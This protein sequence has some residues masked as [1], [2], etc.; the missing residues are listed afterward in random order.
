MAGAF[1]CGQPSPPRDA[2]DGSPRRDYIDKIDKIEATCPTPKVAAPAGDG[3]AP[4]EVID[5]S[6]LIRR[7]ALGRSLARRVRDGALRTERPG[8]AG[9][10]QDLCTIPA[11]GRQ[12]PA[13]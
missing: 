2:L 7:R 5:A 1:V 11:R 4:V 12:L 13:I 6:A 9:K 3:G 10:G 8:V